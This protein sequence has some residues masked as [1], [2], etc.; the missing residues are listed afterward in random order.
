MINFK[1]SITTLTLILLLLRILGFFRTLEIAYLFGAQE[2]LDG[3][4]LALSLVLSFYAI[5]LKAFS[6]G[7][8]PYLGKH[9]TQVDFLRIL[10]KV[11]L[12]A[13]T[14]NVILY[15]FAD[16][17]TCVIGPGFGEIGAQTASRSIRIFSF[18]VYPLLCNSLFAAYLNY[19]KNYNLVYVGDIIRNIISV[20]LIYIWSDNVFGLVI[21]WFIG[22]WISFLYIGQKF[23]YKVYTTL[24]RAIHPGERLKTGV[25][26]S[27]LINMTIYA[28][29]IIDKLFLSFST[30]GTIS[31]FTYGNALRAIILSTFVA[32]ASKIFLVEFTNNTSHY[33]KSLINTFLIL[34]SCSIILYLFSFSIS[35]F[36]FYRGEISLVDIHTISTVLKLVA[37]SL[38]FYSFYE[39]LSQK[40]FSQRNYPFILRAALFLL[41][42]KT[43]ICYF[44][45]DDY[46]LY[47]VL[48]SKIFFEIGLSISIFIYFGKQYIKIK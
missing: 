6:E 21:A 31:N 29:V 7:I 26:Y 27:T 46:G 40:I 24:D 12:I 36:F 3:I 41:L 44:T 48:W 45:Y 4:F 42:V 20:L 35:K 33:K 37:L 17:I 43:L 5:T 13:I 23:W 14:L 39:I 15:Y 47:S 22:S 18:M 11:L 2:S 9:F 1:R 16:E 38:P 32:A 10:G 34:T 30:G 19:T 28:S 8:I 25:I